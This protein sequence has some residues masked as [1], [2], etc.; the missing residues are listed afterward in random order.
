MTIPNEI[1]FIMAG[2]I[3]GAGLFSLIWGIVL[4]FRAAARQKAARERSQA[5]KTIGK[6]QADIEKAIA[7]FNLGMPQASD[8][9]ST[10]MPLLD[11]MNQELQPTIPVLDLYQAR[12]LE[13]MHKYYW[14][15]FLQGLP[16]TAAAQQAQQ[17]LPMPMRSE[18]PL[19]QQPAAP[20]Q[21]P[22]AE[23]PLPMQPE[24]APAEPYS[25]PTAPR[26]AALQPEN[27]P[28]PQ[29]LFFESTPQPMPRQ[30]VLPPAAPAARPPLPQSF[31]AAELPLFETPGIK[32]VDES[33]KE[34]ER[35][36]ESAVTQQI[37]RSSIADKAFPPSD[38]SP[39]ATPTP[40]APTI[41]LPTYEPSPEQ[42]RD[43]LGTV[44]SQ[45]PEALSLDFEP[46]P[47]VIQ[48]QEF[49]DEPPS[50]VRMIRQPAFGAP[51]PD[52]VAVQDRQ[53]IP[54]ENIFG[55]PGM[56]AGQNPSFEESSPKQKKDSSII[57]GDD[58]ASTL[59][60]MFGAMG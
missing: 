39:F 14:Q 6:I 3:A 19:P 17:P 10:M 46:L 25:A 27:P 47:N 58:V 41:E 34:F 50:T 55:P 21:P 16:A 1:S 32:I 26:P 5:L 22:L 8:L 28:I 18:Q 33:A 60:S 59:D 57:S 31:G 7:A 54:N 24:F 38:Q 49:L 15:I 20:V 12:Y 23:K 29:Q 42:A 2:F 35:E 52:L 45:E 53:A 51:E 40:S 30:P 37:D 44:E 48:Q 43:V 11:R 56:P 36:L 4:I 9:R 13:A